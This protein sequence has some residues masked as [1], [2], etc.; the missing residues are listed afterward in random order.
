MGTAGI[1]VGGAV[2]DTFFKDKSLLRSINKSKTLNLYRKFI[3][4]A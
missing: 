3:I 4:L 1:G 2:M